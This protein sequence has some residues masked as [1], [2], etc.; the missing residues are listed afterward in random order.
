MSLKINWV[1]IEKIGEKRILDA[2]G[3]A[4]RGRSPQEVARKTGIP[5]SSLQSIR[6]NGPYAHRM[7]RISAK[8][9]R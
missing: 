7:K 5:L 8:R 2:L 6:K 1:G 9:A 3:L 4:L